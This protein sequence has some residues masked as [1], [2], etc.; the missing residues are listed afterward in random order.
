LLT[1]EIEARKVG[2]AKEVKN[3]ETNKFF[4]LANDMLDMRSVIIMIIGLSTSR[5]DGR[6]MFSGKFLNGGNGYEGL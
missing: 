4:N 3:G 5:G 1:G 6:D 2:V